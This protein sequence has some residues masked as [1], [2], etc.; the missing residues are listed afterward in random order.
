MA[1]WGGGLYFY[2]T[3]TEKNYSRNL[4]MKGKKDEPIYITQMY[5]WKAVVSSLTD[6]DFFLG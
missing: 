1:P 2:H 4:C 5:S 6:M 3:S